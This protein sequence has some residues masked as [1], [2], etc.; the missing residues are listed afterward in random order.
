MNH[1]TFTAY[2]LEIKG[3]TSASDERIQAIKDFVLEKISYSGNA[4]DLNA[5]LPYFVYFHFLEDLITDTS[6]NTG[7]TAIIREQSNRDTAKMVKAWN[8]GVER[9]ISLL[10]DSK[11]TC[12]EKYKSKIGIL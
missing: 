12:N 8:E 1:E 6:V 4:A 3:I 5:L 7:E 11:E 9:L 10:A 2:P